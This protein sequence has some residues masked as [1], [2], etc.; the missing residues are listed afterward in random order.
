[1][2]AIEQA[3]NIIK[4]ILIPAYGEKWV[5]TINTEPETQIVCWPRGAEDI[6]P[7]W[8]KIKE[9]WIVDKHYDAIME[10]VGGF[11]AGDW[12]EWIMRIDG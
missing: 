12:G 7:P 2:T 6:D 11:W 3:E 8:L 9:E 1:M 5:F 10:K 4:Y